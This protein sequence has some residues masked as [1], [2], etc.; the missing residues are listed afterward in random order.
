[1]ICLSHIIATRAREV[2]GYGSV[3]GG[4][5]YDD[6]KEKLKIACGRVSDRKSVV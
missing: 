4:E 5:G 2:G 1:M 3:Q 6:E